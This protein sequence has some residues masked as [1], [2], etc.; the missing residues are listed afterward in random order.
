MSFLPLIV[1]VMKMSKNK[2]FFYKSEPIS[3]KNLYIVRI[4]NVCI[5]NYRIFQIRIFIVVYI[6]SIG[7]G[8]IIPRFFK[9]LQ[10]LCLTI[11]ESVHTHS[12][13]PHIGLQMLQSFLPRFNHSVGNLQMFFTTT[14]VRYK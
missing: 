10:Q 13:V 8:N 11:T 2:N 14:V 6:V 7:K 12:G 5:S 1:P 9:T 3:L 4:D